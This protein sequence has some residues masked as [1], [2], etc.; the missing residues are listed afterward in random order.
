VQGEARKRGACSLGDAYR[1]FGM[2]HGD[3]GSFQADT[4][5]AG[6]LPILFPEAA[7]ETDAAF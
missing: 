2:R 5:Q 3:H 7:K 6:A 4:R 1:L